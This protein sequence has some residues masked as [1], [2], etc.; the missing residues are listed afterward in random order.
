[1]LNLA[2]VCRLV[3]RKQQDYNDGTVLATKTHSQ[4]ND[5]D[6]HAQL[7]REEQH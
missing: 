6:Q 2:S 5:T 4:D 3:H 1:M 7:H